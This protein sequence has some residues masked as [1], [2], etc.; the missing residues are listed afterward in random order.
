YSRPSVSRGRS[1]TDSLPYAVRTRSASAN[2]P[3]SPFTN[4]DHIH[5][6]FRSNS[7]TPPPSATPGTVVTAVPGS[8]AGLLIQERMIRRMRSGSAPNSPS[9]LTAGT[10][11]FFPEEGLGIKSGVGSP[12]STGLLDANRDRDEYEEVADEGKGKEADQDKRKM[13]PPIPEFILATGK[14]ELTGYERRKSESAPEAG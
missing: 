3:P 14:A 4:E 10:G 1:S 6:L 5:P 11:Y 8:F 9:P 7:P 2:G 12:E 13:T